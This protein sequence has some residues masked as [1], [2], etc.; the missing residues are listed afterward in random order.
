MPDL[1]SLRAR[2]QVTQFAICYS[3]FANEG[4]SQPRS[5]TGARL[6]YWSWARMKT[7]VPLSSIRNQ[8]ASMPYFTLAKHSS[9]LRS[10]W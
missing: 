4:I 1:T 7:L 9:M 3:L 2:V 5:L 10:S 8:P 6:F